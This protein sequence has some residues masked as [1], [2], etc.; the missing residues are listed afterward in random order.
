[1]RKIAVRRVQIVAVLIAAASG[2]VAILGVNAWLDEQISYAKAMMV[3][4]PEKQIE[5][6][7]VV[8]A[9]EELAFGAE[10]KRE[11]L[12]EVEWPATAVP[13]GSF[14]KLDDI[15]KEREARVVL[16]TMRGNEPVLRGK[17]SG[18]G[19]RAS[20]SNMLAKGMKAVSIRVNDVIGVSGFVLPGDRVDVLLTRDESKQS[21]SDNKAGG[22]QS[23]NVAFT[24]LL[25]ENMRVLAIDQVSD[26]KQVEPKL[27]RTVTVEATMEQ[28]QKITLA[29]TVGT[30][31]L[32][33]RESGSIVLNSEP[34]RVAVADLDGDSG[35][36]TEVSRFVPTNAVAPTPAPAKK[37]VS[38]AV[39]VKVVRAAES[40]EYSVKRLSSA[41]GQ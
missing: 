31:S 41:P 30:L 38:D 21:S 7:T 22:G 8:V 3:Q 33:L 10:L 28:A 37:K 19:Q 16:E 29:A 20:L 17:I 15:F 35:D 5:L 13:D 40:S 25:L 6:T 14:Q 27:G 18:P 39:T 9:K 12:T 24:D 26:P 34:K 4:Q 32:V 1:M 23:K 2:G 36:K 11:K